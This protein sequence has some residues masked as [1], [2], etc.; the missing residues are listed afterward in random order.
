MSQITATHAVHG[1]CT[2]Q[3][4][5]RLLAG[6]C[7]TY[8]SAVKL[9]MLFRTVPVSAFQLRSNFVNLDNELSPVAVE[10]D[11]ALCPRDKTLQSYN[12]SDRFACHPLA[13]LQESNRFRSTYASCVA[14]VMTSGTVPL[15]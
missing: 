5:S 7:A 3:F 1:K 2:F 9:E 12:Q 10:P 15:S 4:G 13:A 14:V 11:R 6:T 8:A